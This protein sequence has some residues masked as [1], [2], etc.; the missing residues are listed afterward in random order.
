[1]SLLEL[2]ATL[3]IKVVYERAHWELVNEVKAIRKKKKSVRKL[4]RRRQNN[5]LQV[6]LG[7]KREDSLK[8]ENCSLKIEDY[9]P[10]GQWLGLCSPYT[11]GTG[12]I[13]DWGT[14]IPHAIITP[15]TKKLQKTTK[16]NKLYEK[17]RKL[18]DMKGLLEMHIL[19]TKQER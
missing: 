5:W 14:K 7:R 8:I 17:N 2:T 15:K 16:K 9:S 1:L 13:P 3:G 6:W 4:S 19:D 10:A 18:L 11:E 12:L